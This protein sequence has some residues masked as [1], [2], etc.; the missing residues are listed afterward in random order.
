MNEELLKT[1]A[2]YR[3]KSA[4]FAAMATALERDMPWL[5]DGQPVVPQKPDGVPSTQAIAD[6]L[7]KVGAK[8][9]ADIADELGASRDVI[10]SIIDAN[11]ERFQ[12]ADRGWVRLA[13]EVERLTH[14]D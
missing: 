9:P 3:A 8:R 12:K 1:I 7:T 6:Y 11:P 10:L 4:E 14:N 5:S 13:T 2:K